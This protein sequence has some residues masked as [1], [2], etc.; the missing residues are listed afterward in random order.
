[1]MTVGPRHARFET[2]RWSLVLAA[3]GGES[4]QARQALAA[5]CETYWYPLYA[6]VRRQNYNADDAQDLTQAF[7]ARL[8]EKQD[9][10]DARRARGRF[11]SFLL[12]A[13]KHFLLNEAQHRR[14]LKRGGGQTPLSIEG[15]TAEGRYRREPPD[16]STPEVV[17]DRRWALTVLDRAL[18]RLRREA[19]EAGKTAEFDALKACLTGDIP[20]GS[21]RMIGETLGLSEG[22]VKVAV[23][24]LRRRFQR[25]LR[26]EISE[27][28]LTDADVEK[29]LQYLFRALTGR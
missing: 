26:A 12:A 14:A 13:M 16:T 24:R 4:S 10:Q 18:G 22:A 8:I 7:F 23:H 2:T 25:A 1:M 5:L 3:G 17:F 29:E 20:H 19:V 11:R 6:Y 21:Y 15:D 9:V 28:V 27:T